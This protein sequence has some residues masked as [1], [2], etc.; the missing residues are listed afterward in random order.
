MEGT[1]L[2]PLEGL[3]ATLNQAH[4]YSQD[5]IKRLVQRGYDIDEFKAD[6]NA[7][8]Q[9]QERKRKFRWALSLMDEQMHEAVAEIAYALK[10]DSGPTYR[11]SCQAAF[12]RLFGLD[13]FDIEDAKAALKV[14]RPE[15]G[16]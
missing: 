11:S 15:L 3:N 1:R 4:S 13:H 5:E 16:N 7:F 14:I 10:L 2:D 9:E 8:I 6:L 12:M